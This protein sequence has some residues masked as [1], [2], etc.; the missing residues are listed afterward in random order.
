MDRNRFKDALWYGNDVMI[1]LGGAGGIGR[2]I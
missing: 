1:I 2:F